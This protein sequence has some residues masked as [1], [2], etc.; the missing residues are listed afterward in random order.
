MYSL[1]ISILPVTYILLIPFRLYV[2]PNAA[3]IFTLV[4]SWSTSISAI[5]IQLLYCVLS[6]YPASIPALILLPLTMLSLILPSTAIFL[7]VE[8][9]IYP[10]NPTSSYLSVVRLIP[11]ILWFCPSN[12][13]LLSLP[14][15]FPIGL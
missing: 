11:V 8:P 15:L 14:L 6:E 13:I 3:P 1:L 4:L 7:T 2:L 12:V 5:T 10:N 9:V